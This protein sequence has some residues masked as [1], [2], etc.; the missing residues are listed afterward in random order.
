[1][2]AAGGSP[3]ALTGSPWPRWPA[4]GG[5]AS[6]RARRAKARRALAGLNSGW[7][8]PYLTGQVQAEDAVG[9]EEGLELGARRRAGV[10]GQIAQQRERMHRVEVVEGGPE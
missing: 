2:C 7:L 3:N 8:V 5:A 10:E 4:A 6:A 9:V 1:M